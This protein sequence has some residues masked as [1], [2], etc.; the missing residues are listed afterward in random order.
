LPSMNE[1]LG[2]IPS[3]IIKIIWNKPRQNCVHLIKVCPDCKK[4]SSHAWNET[5][6]KQIKNWEVVI[7]F[8]YRF[9]ALTK[10]YLQVFLQ[11]PASLQHFP[12]Y[13]W[14]HVKLLRCTCGHSWSMPLP[15]VRT[16]W[17]GTQSYENVWEGPW[18][19]YC[20]RHPGDSCQ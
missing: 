4:K 3:K 11:M 1:A 17:W 9:L 10:T 16:G 6:L 7:M 13:S 5:S 15:A 18:P 14:V 19:W 8:T 20:S 2:S 12:V